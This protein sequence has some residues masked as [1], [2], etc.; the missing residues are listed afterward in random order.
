MVCHDPRSDAWSVLARAQRGPRSSVCVAGNTS[1]LPVGTQTVGAPHPLRRH[2]TVSNTWQDMP[3]ARSS[4]VSGLWRGP[5]GRLY[6][7]GG[8]QSPRMLCDDCDGWSAVFDHRPISGLVKMRPSAAPSLPMLSWATSS[9]SRAASAG[10]GAPMR[11]AFQGQ[12]TGCI[13][14]ADESAGYPNDVTYP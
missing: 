8:T 10:V 2:D 9:L 6:Y 11:I 3:D 14:K 12:T 1:T 5:D 4:R 13:G 7:I